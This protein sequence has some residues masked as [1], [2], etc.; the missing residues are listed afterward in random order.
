MIPVK[1][2]LKKLSEQF[3]SETYYLQLLDEFF[4]GENLSLGERDAEKL[5][6]VAEKMPGLMKAIYKEAERR[7]DPRSRSQILEDSNIIVSEMLDNNS[8]NSMLDNSTKLID[9]AE[10]SDDVLISNLNRLVYL[11]FNGTQD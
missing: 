3:F 6:N 10:P 4:P 5:V 7:S 8:V 1:E 2:N 11:T 9:N